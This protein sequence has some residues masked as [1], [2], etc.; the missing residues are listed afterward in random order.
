MPHDTAIAVLLLL[1]ACVSALPVAFLWV[2]L[3]PARNS[4]AG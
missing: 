2:A 4:S 3:R 1:V